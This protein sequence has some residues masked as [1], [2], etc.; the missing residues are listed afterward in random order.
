[1]TQITTSF[2]HIHIV[3]QV[4]VYILQ[5]CVTKRLTTTLSAITSI[6]FKL[7]H[8]H[9][10]HCPIK[11]CKYISMLERKVSNKCYK[12]RFKIYLFKKFSSFGTS[13]FS[14]TLCPNQGNKSIGHTRRCCYILLTLFRCEQPTFSRIE[15][16]PQEAKSA[17]KLLWLL[18]TLP[19]ASTFSST[20]FRGLGISSEV[21]L[22]FPDATPTE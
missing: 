6:Y 11:R 8:R 3:S 15:V 20:H 19:K 12:K 17:Q 9:R 14:T 21:W 16:V 18:I 7:W 22:T 5:I 1:M 13:K 4:M 2:P 10:H